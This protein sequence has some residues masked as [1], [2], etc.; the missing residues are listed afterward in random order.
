MTHLVVLRSRWATLLCPVALGLLLLLWP[1]PAL[2]HRGS[3]S[4]AEVQ[5]SGDRTLVTFQ[6]RINS[7]DMAE[8]LG[9]PADT[10]ATTEQITTGAQRILDYVLARIDVETNGATCP[11]E[12]IGVTVRQQTGRFAQILWRAR[13]PQTFRSLAVDYRLF[14]DLDPMHSS[15]LLVKVGKHK[16]AVALLSSSASR[17]EWDDLGTPPP[18]SFV[19]FVRSGVEHI[20]WG[21]DHVAFVLALLLVAV[22]TRRR[23]GG[24]RCRTLPEALRYIG[25][26]ITSFTLGHSLTLASAALGWD[27]LPSRVVESVIAL[28]IVYVA[29]ENMVYPQT[30]LRFAVALGFGLMHG[31]GFA[32]Q[33]APQLP[34]DQVVVPLLAFNVG[35]ELGQLAVVLVLVPVAWLVASKVTGPRSYRRYVAPALSACLAVAG[36]VWF[37]SRAFGLP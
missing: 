17:F 16:P 22:I 11:I 4:Y 1:S 2:A 33:L 25:V 31:F 13:C 5:V 10:D 20:L 26:V 23:E 19:S 24:W 8:P 34:P 14:F 32:S 27:P 7:R 29:V 35:V 18:S 9:L 28:S 21:F 12:R 30:K 37:V 3:I 36:A 6:L 15:Q